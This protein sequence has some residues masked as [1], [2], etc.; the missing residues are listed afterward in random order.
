MSGRRCRRSI[1]STIAFLSFSL[2]HYV[3]TTITTQTGRSRAL[4]CAVPASSLTSTADHY[5]PWMCADGEHVMLPASPHFGHRRASAPL[6]LSSLSLS[7]TKEKEEKRQREEE[8]EE[9]E[10][11]EEEEEEK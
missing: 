3:A 4:S 8:E 1:S 11:E 7:A 10:D 5:L 2:C 9:E 6:V